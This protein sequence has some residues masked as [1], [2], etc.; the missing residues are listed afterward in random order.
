[1]LFSCFSNSEIALELVTQIA[2]DS[3]EEI[4]G[5]ERNIYI[6]FGGRDHQPSSFLR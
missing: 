1:M 4:Q 6:F 3:K 5:E 2:W